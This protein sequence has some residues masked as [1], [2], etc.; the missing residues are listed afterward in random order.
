MNKTKRI[1]IVA[2][3]TA[4]SFVL[5][6]FSIKIGFTYKIT[7]YPI[8]LILNGMLFGPI[9]GLCAGFCEGLLVQLLTPDYITPTFLLW[10]IAPILWG[11]ISSLLYKLFKN[12]KPFNII[13]SILITSLLVTITNTLVLYID[14][15]IMHYATEFTLIVILTRLITSLLSSILYMVVMVLILPP[16]EKAIKKD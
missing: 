11:V 15:L 3:I 10:M 4:L 7:L 5:D 9:Y 12:K 8:P 16:L 6:Y 13:L 2:L 14:G 1:T